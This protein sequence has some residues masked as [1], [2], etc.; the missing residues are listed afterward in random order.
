MRKSTRKLKI[1]VIF[2]IITIVFSGCWDQHPFERIGFITIQG[3]DVSNSFQMKITMISP[4]T[5]PEAKSRSEIL[6]TTSN[7]LR[8]SREELRRKSSKSMEAGKIQILLYSREIAEQQQISKINDIFER[9][10]ANSIIAWLVVV[11]G[12]AEEFLRGVEKLSDKQR[13]SVYLTQLLERNAQFSYNPETRIYKFDT[14]SFREGMDNIAP[15][16]KLEKD[17][18]DIKGTALFSKGKLVGSLTPRNTSLLMAMMGNLKH[19][20][21]QFNSLNLSN[22]KLKLK[23]GLST[24]LSESRR[25]IKVKIINNR[26]I[27]N[28]NLGLS[29]TI[30]EYE[31]DEINTNKNLEKINLIMQEELNKNF[32]SVI[33]YLQEVNSDPIGIGNI[34]R[35][36]YNNYWKK[37][38]WE[39]AYKNAKINVHVKLETTHY[40]V[41][42]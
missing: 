3:I 40:G 4:V 23:H 37:I 20:E 35:A 10:P 32:N 39:R 21:Y 12:N 2:I 29:G 17:G 27:V 33:N 31:A 22:D 34:I 42:H 26:P 15:L 25:T 5:D 13:P 6:T 8:S 16:V 38:N 19:T 24:I 11:D 14:I 36:K 18:V 28:I 41:T 9:D 1:I 30:D 7:L